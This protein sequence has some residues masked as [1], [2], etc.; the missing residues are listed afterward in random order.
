MALDRRVRQYPRRTMFQYWQG[1]IEAIKTAQCCRPMRF[2]TV[3][4]FA[5]QRKAA[6]APLAGPL[7]ERPPI[8]EVSWS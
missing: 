7:Q 1:S 2:R 3:G 6:S 8:S 4:T 5:S